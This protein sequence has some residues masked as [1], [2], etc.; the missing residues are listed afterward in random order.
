[1]TNASS[2]KIPE[3]ILFVLVS[4]ALSVGVYRESLWGNALLAPLDLGPAFFQNYRFMDPEAKQVPENHYIVD[5]FTYDLPLQKTI[6]D[7]YRAGEVP[8]W[9]PYTYGGRPLLADA[10]VNGTDPIRLICYAF[11]PFEWAYNW[12]IVL[13]GIITGL[14]M[15]LLLRYFQIDALASII[16]ALTYQFG[17]WF[18][19][20]FGHPWIQASFMYYPFLWLVWLKG[21][22]VNVG[23]HDALAGILCALV[24]WSGNLQSHAYL[25]LFAACFLSGLLCKNRNQWW[26]GFQ[27]AALSGIIGALLAFPVLANQAEFFLLSARS[28]EPNSHRWVNPFAI[29]TSVC[30]IHPWILGTFKTLDAGKMLGSAGNAFFLFCGGTIS[31]LALLGGWTLRRTKGVMGTAVAQSF[32]IVSLYLVVISTPLTTI[33]YP[34]LAGMPGMAIILLGGLGWKH[35]ATLGEL[36]P[37]RAARRCLAVFCASLVFGTVVILAVFPKIQPKIELKLSE[38]GGGGTSGLATAAL[39]QAQ[40]TRLP[41]E[42]TLLNPEALVGFTA[43]TLLLAGLSFPQSRHQKKLMLG[44]LIFGAIATIS[45]HHRFRPKH[46]I[47]LWNRLKE[48]GILQKEAIAAL[49]GGLRLNESATASAKQIFPYAM[50]A[51]YRVHVVHGYSALQPRSIA[52]CRESENSIGFEATADLAFT[53]ADTLHKPANFSSSRFCGLPSGKSIPTSILAESQ[54][55]LSVSVAPDQ[56]DKKIVRTDTFYPGW[57]LAEAPVFKPEP[58]GYCFSSWPM[59]PVNNP[60]MTFSYKPST[61][62]LWPWCF[63]VGAFML[64]VLFWRGSKKLDT[65]CS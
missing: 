42:V 32:L 57:T 16:L 62:S 6:Y 27:M 60:M 49:R 20:Y 36:L 1:M 65:H 47:A 31:I 7:S 56:E 52:N 9:D 14:G 53:S 3:A 12:N 61:Y 11:L 29:P 54:N 51:M 25:P 30:S 55:S 45:F 39:R 44:A 41:T 8:W 58:F 34:R 4:L 46:D 33:L 19:M 24:F 63:S 38:R 15:F 35:W 64:V 21:I 48:G 5:Q 26:R 43:V 59:P 40:I 18:T 17:G 50:A 10:H 13:R 28:I 2:L 23:R 37:R 22:Q